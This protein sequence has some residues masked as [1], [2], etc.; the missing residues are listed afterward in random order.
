MDFALTPDQVKLLEVCRTL[1]GDFASRAADHDR[2]A[3]S[4]LKDYAQLR[5]AGLYGLFVPKEYGGWG[6][7][8]VDYVL[9]AEELAAGSASTAL[10]F[11]MHCVAMAVLVYKSPLPEAT[12]RR[13][14]DLAVKDGKLFCGLLSE[15]GTTGL[16]YSSRACSTTARRT[17]DGYVLNGKK[18][19][20]TMADAADVALVFAR[21]EDSPSPE[22][23][24]PILV[25]LDTPGIRIEPVW[26]TLGMRATRSDHLVLEDCVVPR[27]AA[28]EELLVPS[29]GDFLR[30]FEG[31]INL[32]YTAVYLGVGLGAFKEAIANVTERVPKGG[33][34]PLAYHPDIR[35]RIAI[36]SAELEAAHRLLL[37]AAWLLDTDAPPPE[38]LTAF[39]KAKYVVGEAVAAAT[40][41]ALE[42]GGGHAIFKGSAIERLFR[43][44][45][46]ATIMQPH[47]DV[48]LAQLGIHELDLDPAEISP[49]LLP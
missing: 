46:T 10:S 22:A 41:S 1:A 8:F 30:D 16:V 9:A 5:D 42:M 24:V 17:E 43:D 7:G 14:A 39:L 38:A 20:A 49:P 3:S 23:A 11:N 12:K 4:P 26:D 19:F 18:A 48:C 21:P 47:S 28:L 25:P 31:P 2:D 35:R 45:A 34:Q 40:R 6:T 37:Y 33:R 36:M 29:I 32:P 15:P 44:G 13:I 27:E